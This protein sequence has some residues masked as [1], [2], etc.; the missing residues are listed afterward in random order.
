MGSLVPCQGSSG[1]SPSW[2]QEGVIAVIAGLPAYTVRHILRSRPVGYGPEERSWVPR[3]DILDP[4]LIRDFLQSCPRAVAGPSAKLSQAWTQ[5][6]WRSII[7][8]SSCIYA[9]R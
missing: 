1:T 9:L 4:G 7:P 5:L 8:Q 6:R 3:R 2:L